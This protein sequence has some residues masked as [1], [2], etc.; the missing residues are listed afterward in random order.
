MIGWDYKT[1]DQSI[2]VG[3]GDVVILKTICSSVDDSKNLMVW[4]RKL[5]ARRIA[6]GRAQTK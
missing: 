1:G 2:V 4:Y 6:A 3:E 5:A